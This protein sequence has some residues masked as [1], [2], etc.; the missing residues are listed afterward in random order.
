VRK[1]GIKNLLEVSTRRRNTEAH[2]RAGGNHEDSEYTQ[3][4]GKYRL[5]RKVTENAEDGY[6][7]KQRDVETRNVKS[8]LWSKLVFRIN[9]VHLIY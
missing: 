7:L 3:Y 6:N 2:A 9:N 4:G 5:S 1:Y 8:E